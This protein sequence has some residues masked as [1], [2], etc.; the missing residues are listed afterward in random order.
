MN[1][2]GPASTWHD[3]VSSLPQTTNSPVLWSP[4]EQSE[5]LQGSPALAE[6]QARAQALNAEWDSINQQL[7]AD[8]AQHS[9]CKALTPSMLLR[10]D[11]HQHHLEQASPSLP[12][13]LLHTCLPCC[14]PAHASF[15]MSFAT[16]SMQLV[17]WLNKLPCCCCAA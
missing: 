17:I 16:T 12:C 10:H 8:P 5:L 11:S 6:A 13:H 7:T 2:Q 15:P 1:L 14:T 4:E 9:D 3:F